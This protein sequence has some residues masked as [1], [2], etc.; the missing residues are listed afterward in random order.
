MWGIYL[1]DAYDPHRI[2]VLFVHGIDG[3]PLDFRTMVGDL[4]TTR[5][6]AWFYY[7]PTGLRLPAASA[8]LHRLLA[9][10][11]R[12]HH[13]GGLV[14]VAHSMGGL[15]ARDYLARAQRDGSE[16]SPRLLVT[17]SS[18]WQGV[19]SAQAGAWLM[20]SPPES[21]TD[22]S[23]ESDFLVSLRAPLYGVPHYVFFGYRRHRSLLSSQSSDG[24]ITVLS[25]LP[26]W[27]QDQAVRYWGYDD[28]HV[29]ILSDRAVLAQFRA[30][31]AVE[32]RRLRAGDAAPAR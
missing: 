17:L 10:L 25:Q 27:I 28:D 11:E 32:F 21:W 2:P 26:R 1:L 22:L 23:P 15:V 20:P 16:A 5:F 24:A 8:A 12:K 18:P 29:G 6:Q 3:T 19:A 30:L 7:Y 14:I 13:I 9:E 31:L 4:D